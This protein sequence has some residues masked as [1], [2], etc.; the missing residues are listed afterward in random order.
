MVGARAQY[1]RIFTSLQGNDGELVPLCL[2]RLADS[3]RPLH[4]DEEVARWAVVFFAFAMHP[5]SRNMLVIHQALRSLGDV[6]ARQGMEDAALNIFVI[7]LE[8]F[9]RM[10]VHQ[11]RAEC[12]QTMGDI[13]IRRG[14]LFKACT[15]WMDARP[16]FE[17]SLQTKGVVEIDRRLIEVE[18]YHEAGVSEQLSKLNVPTE[19]FQ[20]I[21][22]STETVP[23]GEESGIQRTQLNARGVGI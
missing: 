10:D 9:T 5:M 15:F 17:R 2:V 12:M 1:V 4:G 11:S 14:E 7:A 18:Q 13:Y 22:T 20:C 6:L 21:P 23:Q 8:G 3:A 19:L 16:L